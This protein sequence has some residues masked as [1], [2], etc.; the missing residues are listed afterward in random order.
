[1]AISAPNNTF[2]DFLLGLFAALGEANAARLFAPDMIEIKGPRI[3]EAAIDASSRSLVFTEPLPKFR[4]SPPFVFTVAR[5]ANFFRAFVIRA[6]IFWIIGA[7]SRATIR[8]S[9]LI[10]ISLTPAT[11]RLPLPSSFFFDIHGPNVTRYIL[12]CKPDK[13]EAVE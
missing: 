8:L 9:D 6:A 7:I 3:G 10:R 13:Y 1:M 11:I 4:T 2:R 5:T 12:L